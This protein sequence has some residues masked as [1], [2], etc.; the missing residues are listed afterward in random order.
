MGACTPSSTTASPCFTGKTTVVLLPKGECIWNLKLAVQPPTDNGADDLSG[1][2]PLS[3]SFSRPFSRSGTPARPATRRPSSPS[4]FDRLSPSRDHAQ[5]AAHWR[6]HPHG[7]CP[8][9]LK[10]GVKI[11]IGLLQNWLANMVPKPS[12]SLS[13]V[14]SAITYV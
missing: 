7:R 9:R 11:K 6:P 13:S 12:E 4:Y 3:D 14:R 1:L 8:S 10:Q 2:S 5:P